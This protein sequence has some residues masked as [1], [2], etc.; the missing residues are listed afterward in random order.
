[1]A[2]PRTSHGEALIMIADLNRQNA[3]FR[4][5]L[6]EMTRDRDQIKCL[7]TEAEDAALAE[8]IDRDWW[9]DRAK[10]AEADMREH[11]EAAA[12]L[13]SLR[14]SDGKLEASAR[15]EAF[16]V[17]AWV[18]AQC[19]EDAGA[20]NHCEWTLNHPRTGSLVLLM[21]RKEGKTQGEV[22]AELKADNAR[23]AGE[24]DAAQASVAELVKAIEVASRGYAVL[25]YGLHLAV[26]V[27]DRIS[28]DHTDGRLQ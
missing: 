4:R 10:K 21:Q 9:R 18:F 5:Q 3:D 17:M 19:F 12:V 8:R 1:M 6:D 11:L 15:G 25:P 23:L 2:D 16:K 14:E 24:R 27:A 13:T 20:V 7:L 22:N 26:N 28:H